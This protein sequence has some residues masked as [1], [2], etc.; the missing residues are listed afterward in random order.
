[1][2][3]YI[4]TYTYLHKYIHACMY[5]G[6]YVYIQPSSHFVF[7]QSTT[8]FIISCKRECL[9]IKTK[10]ISK[11]L[12]TFYTSSPSISFSVISLFCSLCVFVY[13]PEKQKRQSQRMTLLG[14][15]ITCCISYNKNKIKIAH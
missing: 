14:I 6:M 9:L 3:A 4:N 5:V 12:I 2:H 13:F 8:I 15:M 11:F 10:E 1:M 7:P